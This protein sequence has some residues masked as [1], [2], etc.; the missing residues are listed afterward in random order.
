MVKLIVYSSFF[1]ITA[2]L[3]G[4]ENTGEIVVS[5]TAVYFEQLAASP[6][7][8]MVNVEDYVSGIKCDV[9]FSTK[10]NPGKEKRYGNNGVF[11]RKPVALALEIVQ[12]NLKKRG[13]GLKIFDVYRPY[14][15]SKVMNDQLTNTAFELMMVDAKKHSRGASVDVSLIS[16]ETGEEI[17]MPSGYFQDNEAAVVDFQHLPENV[18]ENRELLIK[19]MQQHGFRVS[20]DHWWHFDFMGWQGFSLLDLSIEELE[21]IAEKSQ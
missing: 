21:F 12:E 7:N 15:V 11:V 9:R 13:L 17:Q 2:L 18:I 6:N 5:D 10:D 19:V 20:P 16:L 8:Q 1:L 14:S 3:N 4:Q